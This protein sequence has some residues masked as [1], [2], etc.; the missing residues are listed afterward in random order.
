[1]YRTEYQVVFKYVNEPDERT[2]SVFDTREEAE[3][4]KAYL[5]ADD[6]KDYVYIFEAKK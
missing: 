2:D 6:D 4:Q 5:E 1:M 3:Q